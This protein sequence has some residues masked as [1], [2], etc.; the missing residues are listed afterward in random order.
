MHKKFEVKRKMSGLVCFGD[1]VLAGNGATSRE[2][3]CAKLIKSSIGIP[4]ALKGRNWNT[5]VDALERINAD[6][7]RDNYSHVLILF[8]N[9]DSWLTG[10]NKTKVDFD[11]FV[12]N[13]NLI[14]DAILENDQV[15]LCF[16]FQPVD[17]EV[18]IQE[19]P[20]IAEY[21]AGMMDTLEG[22]RDKYMQAIHNICERREL[23]LVD[24]ASPLKASHVNV[25]ADDG[26][27]PNDEGHKIIAETAI[28]VLSKM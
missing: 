12:R 2:R 20:E 26:I 8:G 4:T 15:P 27:H 11:L 16:N 7:L 6:V 1:S 10:A 17:F 13:M 5:T 25:I 19:F 22:V 18:F 3:G 9:N 14:I 28:T 21:R 23:P 24:I